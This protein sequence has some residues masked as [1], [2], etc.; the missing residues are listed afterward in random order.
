M[1]FR[2]FY[3]ALSVRTNARR[4]FTAAISDVVATRA[5]V[6]AAAPGA[7]PYPVGTYTGRDILA[8][9]QQGITT[10]ND[11]IA[12]IRAADQRL[13]ALAAELSEARSREFRLRVFLIMFGIVAVAAAA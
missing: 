2:E 4:R 6:A 9:A 3:E 1:D 5:S 8:T 11:L 10:A 7:S 12:R 13:A